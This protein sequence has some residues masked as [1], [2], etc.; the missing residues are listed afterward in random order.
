MYKFLQLLLFTI[1]GVSFSSTAQSL[2]NYISVMR[3]VGTL[4][5]WDGYNAPMYGFA[6]SPAAEPAFPGDIIA[7][8]E[9]DSVHILAS[10]ISREHHTI[11]L[12]GL[13]VNTINDGDP[14]T[15][16]ELD[17]QEKFTYKFKATHAGTYIYHCHTADVV[18]VQMGMYGLVVIR[19]T[20]EK[21]AWTGGPRFDKEYSYLMSELDSVWHNNPPQHDTSTMTVTIPKFSPTYFLVNSKSKQLINDTIKG[22]VGKRIYLRFANI[23]FYDNQII[24]PAG[25]GAT[26]IDSD[27]RPLPMPIVSDTILL[28]PGERYGVMIAPNVVTREFVKVNFID[29]NAYRIDGTEMIPLKIDVALA[30][31][32]AAANENINIFPNP[33]DGKLYLQALSTMADLEVTLTNVIGAVVYKNK[34]TSSQLADINTAEFPNGIYFITVNGASTLTKKMVIAH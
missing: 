21:T 18:H 5:M 1:L 22:D 9:G 24:I 2:K 26:I 13:D 6:N 23:G 27:G 12:H 30:N 33:A 28:S 16:F 20:D 29:M 34:F 4:P 14:M 7:A 25:L 3:T 8:N 32:E 19:P 17:H 15:S 10:N 31:E 11:H